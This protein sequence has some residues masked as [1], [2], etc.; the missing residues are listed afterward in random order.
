MFTYMITKNEARIANMS[1]PLFVGNMKTKV[2]NS[3]VRR[4][5]FYYTRLTKK[6]SLVPIS[7]WLETQQPTPSRCN[8]C[9]AL[10]QRIILLEEQVKTQAEQIRKLLEDR[11]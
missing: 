4:F 11:N 8:T 6:Q 10:Q 5:T 2:G 1:T 9:D 3:Q 7:T